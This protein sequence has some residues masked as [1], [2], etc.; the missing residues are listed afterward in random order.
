MRFLAAVIAGV[1]IVAPA[2]TVTAASVGSQASPASA[3]PPAAVPPA[4]PAQ[5]APSADAQAAPKTIPP[6]PERTARLRD[7]ASV[8]GVRSNQLIGYGLVVGLNGTG[9]RQ[10]TF[11]PTQTLAN[12][13]QRMGVI[14][15]PLTATVKNI[16]AVF[17]TSTLPPFAHP[18]SQVDVTVSSVGDAKSLEGGVLLQT[19]LYASAGQVYAVAQGA[20]TLG[21][22]TAGGRGN[23]KQVNQP[24]VGRIPNGAI[25]ERDSSVDLSQLE[26]VVFLLH[27][28][29]F[30][31]ASEAAQAINIDFGHPLARAVDGTRIEIQAGHNTPEGITDLMARIGN[32]SVR[33]PAVSKVVVN[34]RTGTIVM[35]RRASLGSCSIL[36]GSL[37]IEISTEFQVSQ[38]EP[39]SRGGQTTVVPQ[40]KVEVTEN[41]AQAIHLQE[42]ATVEDLV[43]GLQAIGATAHDII[44][45]L[46]AIK[47]AGALQADLEVI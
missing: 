11:F 9:D 27:D 12:M 4:S 19:P 38:P 30:E 31:V 17:V 16:A 47:S 44:A 2:G 35:G 18:G 10:Q 6:P 29:S 15:N 33:I 43:R 40:T 3:R 14:F 42:G 20:L 26:Q 5:S 21:G 25:V 28:S 45:V 37:A 41:A 23:V 34:E 46:Q 1:I 8:E 32:L 39:F 22:Y 24:T 7:I 36:Q 13:L